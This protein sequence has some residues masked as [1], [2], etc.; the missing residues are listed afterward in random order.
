SKAFTVVVLE[1]PKLVSVL[2][3]L[4]MVLIGPLSMTIVVATE[5]RIAAAIRVASPPSE[6][7]AP[8]FPERYSAAPITPIAIVVIAAQPVARLVLDTCLPKA[9]L[10]L[11]HNPCNGSVTPILFK[12]LPAGEPG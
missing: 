7:P 10:K 11:D 6:L 3:V 4:L 1:K 5:S 12:V 2:Y 8:G 9:C